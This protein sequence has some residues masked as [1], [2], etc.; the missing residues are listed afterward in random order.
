MTGCHLLDKLVVDVA[1]DDAGDDTDDKR[2]KDTQHTYHL[3]PL[4]INAVV[5]SGGIGRIISEKFYRLK[6]SLPALLS[7]HLSPTSS[8]VAARSTRIL[9]KVSPSKFDSKTRPNARS[10]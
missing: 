10:A 4:R 7:F 2:R 3:L 9:E 6:E 8:K 1:S 5:G